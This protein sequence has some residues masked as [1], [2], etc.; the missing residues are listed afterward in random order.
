MK[1]T[2]IVIGAMIL[3]A[4]VIVSAVY[5]KY[6]RTP[7]L[8]RIVKLEKPVLELRIENVQVFDSL[9]GSVLPDQTVVVRE[10]KIVWV[11]ACGDPEIPPTDPAVKR[12]DGRKDCHRYWSRKE[13]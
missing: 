13:R 9:K 2:L 3:V 8:P 12:I 10:D 4:V 1:I 5:L 7:D 11:G 6:A